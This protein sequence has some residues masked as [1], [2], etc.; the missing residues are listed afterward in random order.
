MFSIRNR[1]KLCPPRTFR[2]VNLFGHDPQKPGRKYLL[3]IRVKT[4]YKVS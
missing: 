3:Q 2:N 4:A 1:N